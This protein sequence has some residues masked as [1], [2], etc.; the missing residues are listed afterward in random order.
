M[1]ALQVVKALQVALVIQAVEVIREVLEQA[2]LGRLVSLDRLDL[3]DHKDIQVV[4]V[5]HHHHDKKCLS[6]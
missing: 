2:I 3:Q 5:T 1:K 4:K 6:D